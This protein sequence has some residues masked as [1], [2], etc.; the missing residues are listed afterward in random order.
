MAGVA[1]LVQL[2]ED[3]L[4]DLVTCAGLAHVDS[5]IQPVLQ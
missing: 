2:A 5:V 4:K 3:G 1:E